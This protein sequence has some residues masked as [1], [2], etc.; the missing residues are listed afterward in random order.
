VMDIIKL[1]AAT[2]LPPAYLLLLGQRV[3][4]HCR[5]ILSFGLLI[6]TSEENL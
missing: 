6:E 5:D 1:P 2:S 4:D 3:N